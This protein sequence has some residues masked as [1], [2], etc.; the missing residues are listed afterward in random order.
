MKKHYVSLWPKLALQSQYCGASDPP[1]AKFVSLVAGYQKAVNF[2]QMYCLNYV[3]Y[4]HNDH[5]N[6]VTFATASQND[7]READPAKAL[8]TWAMMSH[9]FYPSN[10]YLVKL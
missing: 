9:R 8:L 4:F 5:A 2:W 1:T 7:D 3:S 10:N 6:V